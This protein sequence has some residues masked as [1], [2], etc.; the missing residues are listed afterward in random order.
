MTVWPATR[1]GIA[2]PPAQLLELGLHARDVPQAVLTESGLAGL[3][4]LNG[5]SLAPVDD[6]LGRRSFLHQ[7]GEE[8]Q[9]LHRSG[10]AGLSMEPPF[11]HAQGSNCH[12]A[13]PGPAWPEKT[14]PRSLP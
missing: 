6:V 1:V 7:A 13:S 9:C 3:E 5:L 14:K 4:L 12:V 11:D 2:K 8:G 10:A